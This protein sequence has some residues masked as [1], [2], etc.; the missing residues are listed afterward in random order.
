MLRYNGWLH[1]DPGT[2][3][4][5]LVLVTLVGMGASG[6]LLAPITGE[7]DADD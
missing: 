5:L 7:D 6:F 3:L 4:I 2:W 1:N